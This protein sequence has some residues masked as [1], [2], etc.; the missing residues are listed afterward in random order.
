MIILEKPYVSE[1]LTETLKKQ[2]YPVLK[3][4]S[5]SDLKINETLNFWDENFA[6]EQLKA[7]KNALIYSNSENS[8]NWITNNL[9]FTDLPKKINLF[10]DK[11]KFRELLTKIYPN[12]YFKEVELEELQ[13]IDDSELIFPFVIKPSVGFL[14]MGVYLVKDSESWKTILKSIKSD[15][16]KTKGI[17]PS[18]VLNSS[19]F[20]IEEYIEGEE[21][22]IDAYYNGQGKPVILNILKHPFSSETDVSDRVYY[23]SSEIIRENL[24]KFKELL[25]KIGE[26]SDLKN[27]PI[28]IELRKDKEKIVPIEVNPMRFAGWCITD[29]AY[30]AYGINIYEYY[31][32]QLEPDWKKILE[33][34]D[35]SI[36]YT[37]IADIPTDL[38]KKNIIK[39][40]YEKLLTNIKEPM[41]I[42]KIDFRKHPLFAIILSKTQDYREISNILKIDFKQ[43]IELA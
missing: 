24:S 6:V 18:E 22:A 21:Y 14:S 10:K 39:I 28:H 26:L 34:D 17:F 33:N 25:V 19:K 7:Q 5:I 9:G 12:F 8:I 42:R 23:T 38:D 11:V 13:N 1:F 36:Y 37:T 35:N 43:Y 16:E 3:N 40:D 32:N 20:I 30:Y 29:L 4:K 31:F 15:I 41:D 2:N 27:F